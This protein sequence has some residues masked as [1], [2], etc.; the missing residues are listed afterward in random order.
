MECCHMGVYTYTVE[1]KEEDLGELLP[2]EWTKWEER[3]TVMEENEF[4]Y[5]D[6][7]MYWE[8]NCYNLPCIVKKTR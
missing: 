1:E 3:V 4:P 2:K 8:K 5:L 6:M 7:K